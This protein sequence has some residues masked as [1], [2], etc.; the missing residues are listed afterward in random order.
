MANKS[1]ENLSFEVQEGQMANK[2]EENLSFEVQ[3]GQNGQ[4]K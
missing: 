4:Q 2:S 3:E 1:E